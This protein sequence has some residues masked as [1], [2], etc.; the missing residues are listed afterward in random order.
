MVMMMQI[1]GACGREAVDPVPASSVGG[2]VG[3]SGIVCGNARSCI[4]SRRS[5]LGEGSAPVTRRDRH[6]PPVG[7]ATPDSGVFAPADPSPD[8]DHVLECWFCAKSRDDYGGPASTIVRFCVYR[9]S[10]C[11]E[12]EVSNATR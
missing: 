5:G 7:P 8:L 1:C 11:Q 6:Q 2:R 4:G 9:R 12:A 3:D 10:V